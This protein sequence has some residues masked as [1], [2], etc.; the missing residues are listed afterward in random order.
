MDRMH[1]WTAVLFSLHTVCL[2]S[3]NTQFWFGMGYDL[4]T[5]ALSLDTKL[6]PV[7]LSMYTPPLSR[8]PLSI[9][10]SGLFLTF[11][12]EQ[13]FTPDVSGSLKFVLSNPDKGLIH[14]YLSHHCT[15]LVEAYGKYHYNQFTYLMGY[16]FQHDHIQAS[17]PQ[18]S[19]H[20]DATRVISSLSAG[21]ETH[22]QDNL[23]LTFNTL[24]TIPFV[25][26]S[27]ST[28]VAFNAKYNVRV[29]LAYHLQT[30]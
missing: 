23:R 1:K 9:D 6:V 4:A 5:Q 16:S 20:Y 30:L 22:I 18:G 21:A 13:A 11:E 3:S 19:F 7:E 26:N 17:T 14:P 12:A 10:E 2:A 27:A 29:G 8:V 15:T 25:E 28:P 24:A